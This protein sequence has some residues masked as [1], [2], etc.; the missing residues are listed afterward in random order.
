MKFGSII[1]TLRTK[2]S[3]WN[4]A[5]RIHLSR[6]NSK[7][8]P[9]LESSCW[10]F[11]WNPERVVLADFLEIETTINSE[12]YIE[13]LTALK[14]TIDRTGIRNETH[15]QHDNA[16]PHTS[17][18]TRDPIQRLDFSVL[19]HPPHSPDLAPSDFHLFQKLKEHLKGQRFS[20]NEEVKSA[21]RKWVQKQN[22]YFFKNG[23]QKLGQR[24]WK[25][26]EVQCV[27]SWWKNNY[28]AWKIIDVGIFIFYFIQISFP[29]HFIFKWRQ[30]LSARPRNNLSLT[31][32]RTYSF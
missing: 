6:K 25:Y 4:T 26:I 3:P 24:W 1:M 20:C 13:T 22:T 28:A 31:Y 23:F 16:R 10:L 5:I 27:A 32:I 21:V 15:L 19:S 14:R 29:V 12:S 18:A 11:F 30:N 7:H 17:V 2:G 8:R 9:W